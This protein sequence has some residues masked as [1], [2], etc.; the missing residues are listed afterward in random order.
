MWSRQL[1]WT[2]LATGVAVAALTLAELWLALFIGSGNKD[3]SSSFAN[4]VGFALPGLIVYSACWY[5]VIFCSRDYS[6]YRTIVLVFATFGAVS[7]I[8]VAFKTIDGLYLAITTAPTTASLGKVVQFIT[9]GPFVYVLLTVIGAIILII[10]YLIV[11]T[12]MALLH[13]WLLLKIFTAAGSHGVVA[14]PLPD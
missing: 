5:V 4:V 14:N 8:V 10:P 7:A 3:P 1:L 12:P 6:L 13:R 11:A 9:L 2:G